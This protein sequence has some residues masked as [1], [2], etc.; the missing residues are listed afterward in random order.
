MDIKIVFLNRD[1]EEETYMEPIEGFLFSLEQEKKVCM[2]VKSLYGLKQ[3]PK[4]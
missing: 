4:Q 2:L 3:A 1:L